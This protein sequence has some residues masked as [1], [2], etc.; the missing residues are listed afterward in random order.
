VVD[1]GLYFAA[2]ERK[3]DRK[4]SWEYGR[5][6]RVA[7][8]SSV[9]GWD[10]LDAGC[11]AGPGL[12]FFALQGSRVYGVDASSYALGR[13]HQL[14]GAARLVQVDLQAGLP[15]ASGYFHLVVL[16]DVIEHVHTGELL[17]R[18]CR[19][20]L[21]PGGVLLVRTVNR[22][23]VRRYWQGRRWSGV[24]DASHV[25]LYSPPEM[26]QAL[27]QAGFS[28]VR[29]RTGVKPMVWL[30]IRWLIGIPWPPLVGNGLLGIAM[31][32]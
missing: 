16:G 29:V 15:F 1:E 27:R 20:V 19:R 7:G 23:D 14:V 24:A 11:G 31:Y 22:W 18:E 28:R 5:L 6:L 25:R 9:H 13:A 8:L 21:R 26:R 30:P 2:Q 32:A 17:L 4:V 12:R 3:S 10:V